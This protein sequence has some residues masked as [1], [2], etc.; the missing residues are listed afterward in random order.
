[1]AYI[2]QEGELENELLKLEIEIS[3]LKCVVLRQ[4]AVIQEIMDNNRY[5]MALLE[6]NDIGIEAKH[7]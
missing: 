6:K 5:L 1:M 2:R 4:C 3:D 7:H